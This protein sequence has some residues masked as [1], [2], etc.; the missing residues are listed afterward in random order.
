MQKMTAVGMKTQRPVKEVDSVP[1]D[2]VPA[3]VH[4][5]VDYQMEMTMALVVEEVVVAGAGVDFVTLME[6]MIPSHQEVA[7]A[8]G[9]DLAEATLIM[10]RAVALVTLGVALVVDLNHPMKMEMT[11]IT[12]VEVSEVEEV[13]LG[14]KEVDL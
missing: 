10:T 14:A 7:V 8:G 11:R 6:M 3:V 9:E 13:D 1:Q 5:V 2:L 4:L 12:V